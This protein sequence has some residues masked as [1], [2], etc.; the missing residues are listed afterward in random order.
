MGRGEALRCFAVVVGLKSMIL[1]IHN[2]FVVA[3]GFCPTQS[4]LQYKRLHTL[5]SRDI[6]HQAAMVTPASGAGLF[7]F[8]CKP[9]T[10]RCQRNSPGGQRV[11]DQRERER[12]RDIERPQQCSC[13]TNMLNPVAENSA[14]GFDFMLPMS[15]RNTRTCILVGAQPDT[16][17]GAADLLP[18]VLALLQPFFFGFS[19]W[20]METVVQRHPGQALPLTASQVAVV[21]ITSALLSIAQ[22][23]E[24]SQAKNM[25]CTH[26]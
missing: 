3:S 5:V 7:T 1:A 10:L 22:G 4:A 8:C 23:G 24:R 12:Q 20:R 16:V 19:T 2:I 15:N 6:Q 26:S 14:Q 21:A 25:S 11:G 17:D 13:L 18:R 9:L